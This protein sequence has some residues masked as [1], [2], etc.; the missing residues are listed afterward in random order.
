MTSQND[1]QAR[2]IAPLKT[3]SDI[4][5]ESAKEIAGALNMVLADVFALYLKTKNFHWHMSGPHFRDY[6]LLLDDPG[7]QI[8]AM[9][10]E[11]AERARKMGGL[12]S[13][14][15][16]L[17]G[18]AAH[19][20]CPH[21]RT[22][23]GAHAHL[24]GAVAQSTRSRKEGPYSRNR[25]RQR[26][27]PRDGDRKAVLL[28]HAGI[29]RLHQASRLECDRH[30]SRRRTG[31]RTESLHEIVRLRPGARAHALIRSKEDHSPVPLA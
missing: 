4:L 20:D 25:K 17:P 11:I 13:E 29:V 26:H 21:D 24:Y 22:G 14:L 10:D 6:H 30:I 31:S 7:E 5:P 2:R 1:L 23:G 12:E 19:K 3:P 15:G 9:A 28:A 8:F 27:R 18:P 16:L